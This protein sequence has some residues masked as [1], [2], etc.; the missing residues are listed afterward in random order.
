MDE[1]AIIQ[2]VLK[3]YGP[4]GILAFLGYKSLP[5][6]GG[7]LVRELLSRWDAHQKFQNAERERFITTLENII[8]HS[9]K[10]AIDNQA[11]LNQIAVT[12]DNH[13]SILSSINAAVSNCSDRIKK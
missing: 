13:S 3:N 8:D 7:W 2:S 1:L 4:F 11:S 12:L 5:R 9:E 6:V 10:I